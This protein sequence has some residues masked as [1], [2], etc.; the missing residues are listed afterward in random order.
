MGGN[1]QHKAGH[2]GAS[3]MIQLCFAKT[4]LIVL[5]FIILRQKKARIYSTKVLVLE[6]KKIGIAGHK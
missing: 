5:A 2:F 6:A 4:P 3:T 1:L